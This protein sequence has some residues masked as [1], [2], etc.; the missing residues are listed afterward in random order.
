MADIRGFLLM[1]PYWLLRALVKTSNIS[2]ATTTGL[3]SVFKKHPN[4]TVLKPIE[5]LCQILVAVHG[6]KGSEVQGYD[7]NV[8]ALGGDTKGTGAIT[9]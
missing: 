6:F 3:E 9:T 1:N 4:A 2:H 8:Y 7:K 5:N